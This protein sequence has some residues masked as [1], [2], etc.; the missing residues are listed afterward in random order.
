[1]TPQPVVPWAR[2]TPQ[3]ISSISMVFNHPVTTLDSLLSSNC[4]W[5][6]L[7]ECPP[8]SSN[9]TWPKLDLDPF[10]MS[11][12]P[13][14]KLILNFCSPL[15]PPHPSPVSDPSPL[16]SGHGHSHRSSL[17]FHLGFQPSNCFQPHPSLAHVFR[18]ISKTVL[19]M[20]LRLLLPPPPLPLECILLSH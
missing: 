17:A 12:F 13:P 14:M 4:S 11:F 10:P 8:G 7:P 16:A 18:M 9:S 6:F 3:R 2:A 15:T 19:T 1:M 5:V 20:S